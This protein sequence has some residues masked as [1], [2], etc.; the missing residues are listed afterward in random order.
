MCRRFFGRIYIEG[1]LMGSEGKHEKEKQKKSKKEKEEQEERRGCGCWLGAFAGFLIFV[2]LCVALVIGG[3]IMWIMYG[4]EGDGKAD[5]PQQTEEVEKK[6]AQTATVN[7][8]KKWSVP[9]EAFDGTN[10]YGRFVS[11]NVKN[12]IN[13]EKIISDMGIDEKDADP[14]EKKRIEALDRFLDGLYYECDKDER[15]SNGDKVTVYIRSREEPDE[16][17]DEAGIIINGIGEHKNVT[18][19]GLA[20]KLTYNEINGR[21]DLINAAVK[22]AKKKIKKADGGHHKKIFADKDKYDVRFEVYG[23]YV[24]K[25][26]DPSRDD[27]LVVMMRLIHKYPDKKYVYWNKEGDDVYQYE[28]CHFMGLDSNTTAED[29]EKG[30]QYDMFKYR[31]K[32]DEGFTWYREEMDQKSKYYLQQLTYNG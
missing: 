26:Y 24:A 12:K 19:D 27:G 5:N 13:R 21:D 28:M 20:V 18:V 25:P 23:V 16:I 29:I 14:G 31:N 17:E 7:V 30:M 3:A 6:Q 1:N 10:G 11:D 15:L 22:A 8:A 32:V 2:T 4:E 9:N